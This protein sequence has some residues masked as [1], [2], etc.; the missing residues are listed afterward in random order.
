MIFTLTF[1]WL[2]PTITIFFWYK[3]KH[4]SGDVARCDGSAKVHDPK[5]HHLFVPVDAVI[6]QRCECA[7][8]R[9]TFCECNERSHEADLHSR[10]NHCPCEVKQVCRR[11]VCALWDVSNLQINGR[12]KNEKNHN[13]FVGYF[14]PITTIQCVVRSLH[15]ELGEDLGSW[16][17]SKSTLT[18]K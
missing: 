3:D 4:T 18:T 5:G 9:H 11:R 6:S 2:G 10:Y 16:T 12:K 17:H 7:S 14:C 13:N 1:S 15:E 8:N